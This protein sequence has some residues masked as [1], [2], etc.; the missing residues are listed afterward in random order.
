M[1]RDVLVC[2]AIS[3]AAATWAAD[4]GQST[5]L[6]EAKSANGRFQ[7]QIRPGRP[8]DNAIRGC[9]AGLYELSGER[10][11]R[12]RWER[13]LV[14]DVAPGRAFIRDDGHFVVTLD[15]YK[16][17]GA[18]N[19]LV[20]YGARGE[21]LRHFLLSDLLDRS[22]WKRVKKDGGALN[23]LDGA[24][25]QFVDSPPMFLITLSKGR[26][27]GI[28]LQK[29]QVVRS[30]GA[31]SGISAVPVQFLDALFSFAASPAPKTADVTTRPA[32]QVKVAVAEQS[33][34][35][36]RTKEQSAELDL[37][38][39]SAAKLRR[40]VDHAQLAQPDELKTPLPQEEEFTQRAEA[41]DNP[42]T[43]EPAEPQTDIP[44]A[45]LP[46]EAPTADIPSSDIP[47]PDPAAPVDYLAWANSMIT[48]EGPSA[49]PEFQAAVDSMS[50]WMGDRNLLK[51]AQ[52]GD[53]AA[54]ASPEV[55]AWLAANQDALDH[56]RDGFG[57]D[58]NG[59]PLASQ[60]GSLILA[61]LPALQAM[62]EL[63]AVSVIEGREFE[64]AGLAGSA[65]DSYVDA[66][67]AG[68]TAG[69][70]PTL[71]ESIVGS[72]MQYTA[73]DA[74]LDLQAGPAGEQLD[75]IALAA[76]LD[77]SYVPPRTLAETVEFEHATFLDTVQRMFDYDAQSGEYVANPARTAAFLDL[78]G[79]EVDAA[80]ISSTTSRIAEAGFEHTVADGDAFFCTISDALTRPYPQAQ[81]MLAANERQLQSDTANPLL[82]GSFSYYRYHQVR[83]KADALQRATRLV[84]R[85]N[86]YRQEYGDYPDS[87]DVFGGADFALDPF[88]GDYLNYRRTGDTF[89]LYSVGVNG[90]DDGGVDDP[91]GET[92][93]IVYWP[94]PAPR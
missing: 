72:S 83:T 61:T 47:L 39:E 85:L 7:L 56:F 62:R 68:A 25:F 28:D 73:A 13:F 36:D 63:S 37:Q 35:Q 67:I 22:G 75:C 9:K 17:G 32:E 1:K 87:L 89:H 50:R 2:T 94:R 24:E 43:T 6:R 21:L 38:T 20:I 14:N 49:I 78:F 52:A 11:H 31:I 41:A 65:A 26:E 4:P 59:W 84:T 10:A 3:V 80:K 93:D 82:S 71:I 12:P 88:T 79:T 92:G 18:R 66:L 34:L 60:D 29:L 91:A 54:L 23:W 90:A 51:A 57:R 46:A 58:Y 76:R 74:V 70:G 53:P 5:P 45:E 30:S 42:L 55:Q 48:T 27:I 19:A 69:S 81:Q 8:G 77:E 44:A 15:E 40:S 64:A 33:V 16:Y 86:A